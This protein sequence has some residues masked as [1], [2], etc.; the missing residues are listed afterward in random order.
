MAREYAFRYDHPGQPIYAPALLKQLS[1]RLPESS[2]VACDVGQHQ[3]WVAQHMRFTSPRNHLSAL[4][5]A[6]WA[7]ACRPPSAPRCRA[8][9]MKWC[10]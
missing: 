9:R 7:S 2:V 8:R 5:L 1:A 10:W 6:P 3:M 4:A